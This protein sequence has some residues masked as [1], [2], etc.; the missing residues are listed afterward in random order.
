VI[1]VQRG[2]KVW[3]MP[4]GS[5]LEDFEK[6]R[7]EGKITLAP[8]REEEIAEQQRATQEGRIWMPPIVIKESEHD[9]GHQQP[10]E[11]ED[12]TPAEE[13]KG[14]GC[15]P[16]YSQQQQPLQNEQK[17]KH[18]EVK[19]QLEE[20]QQQ[21]QQNL[22]V[23]PVIYE[24]SPRYQLQPVRLVS[25][26]SKNSA[27]QPPK[28][29]SAIDTSNSPRNVHNRSNSSLPSYDQIIRNVRQASSMALPSHIQTFQPSYSLTSPT[30]NN[31]NIKSPKNILP[32]R[33]VAHDKKTNKVNSKKLFISQ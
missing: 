33:V 6:L 25:P 13:R 5:K 1:E 12:F 18:E 23:D 10:C 29:L 8:T 22:T 19:Q 24:K 32:P 3:R 27:T 31:S 30:S 28:F 16:R 2:G 26:T 20:Q 11:R 9:T 7:S 15:T 4:M 17:L 21:Q 14:N